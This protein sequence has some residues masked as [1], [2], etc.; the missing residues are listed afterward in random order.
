MLQ[1][2]TVLGK[3]ARPVFPASLRSDHADAAPRTRTRSRL[4]PL[5]GLEDLLIEVRVLLV[6]DDLERVHPA[7]SARDVPVAQVPTEQECVGGLV[8]LGAI[9]P[10]A[11]RRL[12]SRPPRQPA[13][14]IEPP[15]TPNRLDRDTVDLGVHPIAD[16]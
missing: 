9:A 2:R 3:Q 10:G 12:E 11:G 14:L 7:P 5:D 6:V 16:T 15:P 4:D 8:Q 1:P 13:T